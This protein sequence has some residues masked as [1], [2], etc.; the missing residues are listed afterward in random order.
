METLYISTQI[1]SSYKTTFKKRS[2]CIKAQKSN[3]SFLKIKRRASINKQKDSFHPHTHIHSDA[4]LV[5]LKALS[6][7]LSLREKARTSRLF[8]RLP[9][10]EAIYIHT[11]IYVASH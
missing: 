2:K 7:R 5:A 8:G 10:C 9:E 6:R 3:S 4:T 11:H 1:V